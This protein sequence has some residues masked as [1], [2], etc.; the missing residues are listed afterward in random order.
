MNNLKTLF[1]SEIRHHVRSF[2]YIVPEFLKPG[3][4]YDEGDQVPANLT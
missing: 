4:I 1:T 3:M 2:T